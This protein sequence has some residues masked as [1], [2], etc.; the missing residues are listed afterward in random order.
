M[1]PKPSAKINLF[2]LFIIIAILFFLHF[3]RVR[4]D[5]I[6]SRRTKSKTEQQ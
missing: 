6:D 2:L 1:R 3:R 5:I 4:Q